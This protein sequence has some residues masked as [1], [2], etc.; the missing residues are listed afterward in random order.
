MDYEKTKKKYLIFGAGWI[1]GRLKDY[2]KDSA[3]IYS[4]HIDSDT[5]ISEAIDFDIWINTIAKTDIDWCEKNKYESLY[6]NAS[7]AYRLALS[8]KHH[9]K[10]YIFFSSACIFESE[11]TYTL[12]EE[13]AH[14]AY[15]FTETDKP[16][17]QCW[18]SIT[19]VIAEQLVL[20]A[21]PESLIVR[22]RLPISA[23]PHPRNT[24]NKLATYEYI[25]TNQE[26]ITIVEDMIPALELLI[27]QN[28]KGIYHLVN[29]G[30]VSPAELAIS[31]GHE[32]KPVD[33]KEQDERLAK[34]GKA[35]RVTTYVS[36]NYF[37]LPH[38]NTRILQVTNIWKTL[39]TQ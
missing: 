23:I 38:V 8:A 13:V 16:N 28:K 30:T 29:E 9:N 33:K 26:S 27:E 20:E 39:S 7:L 19:K 37:K 6:T 32:F 18:Y 35:K 12:A 36:S 2:F 34:E 3:V 24:L 21:N 22:P 31:I 10:K 4:D 1:A 14:K 15:F 5:V 17:P 11:Q 25:N